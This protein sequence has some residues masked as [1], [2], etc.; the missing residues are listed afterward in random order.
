LS[1]IEK[2]EAE[3]DEDQAKQLTQKMKKN[4]FDYNDFLASTQQ[5]KKM[6]GM[7]G[8]L[9][10]LPGMGALGGKGL[11]ISDE[12]DKRSREADGTNGSNDLFYDAGR[13]RESGFNESFQKAQDC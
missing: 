9:G 5:M 12:T 6:G 13:T 3:I 4:Q 11:K 1:L 8:I 7:S 10:M 2:A